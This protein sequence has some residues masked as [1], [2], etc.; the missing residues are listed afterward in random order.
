MKIIILCLALIGC[1]K[2]SETDKTVTTE[3]IMDKARAGH[4][5]QAELDAHSE[6]IGAYEIT[7]EELE[8]L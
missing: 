6:A 8:D 7:C 2:L 1:T 3:F 5:D 4:C